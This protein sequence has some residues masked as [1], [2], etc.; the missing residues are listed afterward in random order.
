VY[1]YSLLISKKN[2]LNGTI[3]PTQKPLK[4]IEFFIKSY[5][6]KDDLVLDN[7]AGS[8]TVAVAC[9]NL[10]RNYIV[11]EKEIEY[12]NIILK[13]LEINKNL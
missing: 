7:V 11:I 10:E 13:R 6:N 2:K 9:E 12:Y 4:L 5:T 1:R 8:G 3:H